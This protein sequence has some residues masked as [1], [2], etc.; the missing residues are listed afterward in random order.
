[1]VQQVE[2]VRPLPW[3]RRDLGWW[4]G[5]VAAFVM[6]DCGMAL[7]H[8][9]QRPPTEL[10]WLAWTL[11]DTAIRG[12]VVSRHTA[13]E[14]ADI[15]RLVDQRYGHAL[16]ERA[17][18]DA[19]AGRVEWSWVGDDCTFTVQHVPAPPSAR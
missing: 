16:G 10:D 2:K 12:G 19:K 14:C 5:A 9:V 8:P 1:M 6:L 17:G 15:V 18:W 3:Y 13:A 11:D 4:P 7:T